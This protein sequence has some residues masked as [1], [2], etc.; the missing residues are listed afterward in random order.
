MRLTNRTN[1][2]IF[3]IENNK[4]SN[5]TTNGEY[6]KRFTQTEINEI[7]LTFEKQSKF[8]GTKIYLLSNKFEEC[9][10]KATPK[11]LE[12]EG[13]FDISNESG[14]FIM[15]SG[16]TICYNIVSPEEMT[17][18]VFISKLNHLIHFTEQRNGF[19]KSFHDPAQNCQVETFII[20]TKALLN[21]IKYADTQIKILPPKKKI[22]LFHCLYKNDTNSKIQILDS[23]WF[24]TLIQSNEF[25]VRGH[26]RLQPYGPQKMHRKLI[27]INEFK[28]S[29]YH[30]IAGK[31][32]DNAS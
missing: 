16:D 29:G 6:L 32:K 11:L 14:T 9:F 13:F 18:F 20:V 19:L 30:R 24:T 25:N 8:Y 2:V 4:F 22:D 12:I 26:F 1:P 7:R 17:V 23:T 27:W 5:V 15:P 21:F 10:L 31:E 3:N 28:K